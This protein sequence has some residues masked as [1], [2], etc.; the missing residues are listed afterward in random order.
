MKPVVAIWPR[1]SF[2]CSRL[3]PDQMVLCC[4]RAMKISAWLKQPN[5]RTNLKSPSLTPVQPSCCCAELPTSQRESGKSNVFRRISFSPSKPSSSTLFTF[6]ILFQVLKIL[7]ATT[8]SLCTSLLSKV[9]W[10][11]CCTQRQNVN[12][13]RRPDWFKILPI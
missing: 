6:C 7:R 9:Q 10:Q 5:G 12:S 13:D 4:T 8:P 11:Y 3:G 1:Q 2:V